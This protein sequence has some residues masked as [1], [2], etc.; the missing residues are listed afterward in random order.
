MDIN[1][2]VIEK[3]LK[4]AKEQNLTMD[5]L[6]NATKRDRKYFDKVISC[7]EDI[8]IFM[9]FDICKLFKIDVC[10]FLKEFNDMHKKI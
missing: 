8:D 4:T 7:N 3:I 1:K 5:D 6:F 2:L 9:F 10:D